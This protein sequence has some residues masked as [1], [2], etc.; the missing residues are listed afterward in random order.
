MGQDWKAVDTSAWKPVEEPTWKPGI[1]TE[2]LRGPHVMTD[3]PDEPLSLLQRLIDSGQMQSAAHPETLKDLMI[4]LSAGNDGGQVISKPLGWAANTAKN[5]WDKVPVRSLASG[6]LR[7]ASSV[8]ESPLT[9][10]LVSPRAAHFAKATDALAEMIGQTPAR[11]AVPVGAIPTP[12]A[13]PPTP[14]PPPVAIP[15]DVEQELLRRGINPSRIIDVQPVRSVA[16][17]VAPRM[18]T[19]AT[20]PLRQRELAQKFGGKQVTPPPAV[21][22]D[23]LKRLEAVRALQESPSFAKLQGAPTPTPTSQP[24]GTPRVLTR[25]ATP[26]AWT[27]EAAASRIEQNAAEKW[28]SGSE[29]GGPYASRDAASHKADAEMD[30]WYKYFMDNQKSAMALATMPAEMLSALMEQFKGGSIAE[31]RG[32]AR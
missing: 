4:L 22:P 29:S 15:P 1:L 26:D 32:A 20:G 6:T 27:P 14:P 5:V 8:L 28:H 23:E 21:N 2:Q 10:A 13:T 3:A 9:N 25:K 12:A 18:A 7:G 30:H 11:R 19:P 31:P 16:D 24:L 17:Q